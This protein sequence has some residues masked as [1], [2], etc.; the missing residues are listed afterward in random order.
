M[1]RKVSEPIMDFKNKSLAKGLKVLEL[2]C[3]HQE[4]TVSQLS[5]CLD[6]NRVTAHR[7]LA[8]LRELGYVLMNS[9]GRFYL[10]SKVMGLGLRLADRFEIRNIARKHM[11]ALCT[12]F[13]ETVNLGHW[14]GRSLML[15][16]KVES[17]E[18]LRLNAPLGVSLPAYCTASGKAILAFIPE[19]ELVE[20]FKTV[21]LESFGPNTIVSV[22]QLRSELQVVRR[23]GYALEDEELTV[24]L[25]CVA[26]PVVDYRG[27]PSYSLSVAGPKARITSELVSK[28]K[29]DLIQHCHDLSVELTSY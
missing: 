5:E 21:N 15:L 28:I 7:Y 20:Y 10:T 4:L 24:G 6:L 14:D 27:Y 23:Q 19:M 29:D 18:I 9:K 1:S 16:D 12:T 8:A 25:S 2:L 22:K 17:Q 3:E 26:A 11:I 13:G